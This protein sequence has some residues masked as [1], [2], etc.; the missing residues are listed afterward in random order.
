MKG[1]TQDLVKV[2]R[3]RVASQS[4]CHLCITGDNNYINCF[5]VPGQYKICQMMGKGFYFKVWCT[6]SHKVEGKSSLLFFLEA[7]SNF[8]NP[9]DCWKEDKHVVHE[10]G[11]PSL[12]SHLKKVCL[13]FLRFTHITEREKG[14]QF[15]LD[16]FL[17]RVDNAGGLL[18]QVERLDEQERDRQGISPEAMEQVKQELSLDSEHD[19]Y[20]GRGSRGNTWLVVMCVVVCLMRRMTCVSR[21]SL[22][23]LFRYTLFLSDNK[24]TRPAI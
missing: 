17:M 5:A 16:E 13:C 8:L 23:Q 18:A 12:E 14:R 20:W 7:E 22:C 4:G 21:L 6:F 15:M 11:A 9:A 24:V 1:A 2:S 19:Q 10:L 3:R